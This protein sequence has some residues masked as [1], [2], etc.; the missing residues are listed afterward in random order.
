M[1]E[2][3]L[4]GGCFWGLEKYVKQVEGV[5]STESGYANGNTHNPTYEDVCRRNTGHAEAVKV[6]YDEK[7]LPLGFLLDLFF[8]AI[9][10]TSVNRQGGDIGVQYRTGIYY[11]NEKDLSSINH[12]MEKLQQNHKKPIVVEV[13][14]LANFSTAEEYHQNYLDKNQYGYCHIGTDLFKKAAS[15]KPKHE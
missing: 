4:A 12:H 8:D 13:L 6:V 11:T 3:Y 7:A 14:P 10:P 2:I 9:D 1:S 5:L 15:A